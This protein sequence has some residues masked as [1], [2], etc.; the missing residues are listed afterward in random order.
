MYGN[1]LFGG[2]A[3]RVNAS[4]E[5]EGNELGIYWDNVSK[6]SGVAVVTAMPCLGQQH[7]LSFEKQSVEQKMVSG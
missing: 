3:Q 6:S 5:F 4:K 1:H 7:L 2:G